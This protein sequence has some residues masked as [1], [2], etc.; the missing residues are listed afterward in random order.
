[1]VRNNVG[2]GDVATLGKFEIWGPDSMAFLE[3][4]YMNN[5][6]SLP[7]GKGRYGVML[8]EDGMVY[9]D[10]VTSRLG[11]HHFL[12]NTSTGN[13]NSVFEW[14]TQLLET[15]WNSLRVAIVPVT[16]QWFA[17]ALVGP[18]ARKVLNRVVEV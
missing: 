4:V 7:I 1:M 16:D 14:M 2:L 13:T 3:K 5:F 9:D 18:N 15:R 11:E 12:M 8:R 17:A 10:G 6:S